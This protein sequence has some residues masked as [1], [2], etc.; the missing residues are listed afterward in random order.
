MILDRT[1]HNRPW[2][3][4]TSTAHSKYKIVAELDF[5]VFDQYPEKM[6]QYLASLRKDHY[7]PNERIVVYHYDTDFYFNDIGFTL[8]NF[9]MCLKFLDIS[10]SVILMFTSHQGL[11]QE[12]KK[13]YS[14]YYHDFD[15]QNDHMT[16]VDS[17]YTLVQSPRNPV[18]TDIDVELINKPFMCLFGGKRSHRVFFL[19]AL[20]EHRLLEQGICS[21]GNSGVHCVRQEE[22]QLLDL[23]QGITADPNIS[24]PK[25]LTTIPFSR[26]NDHWVP[27]Q[28]LIS[29][30][31]HHGHLYNTPFCH[32]MIKQAEEAGDRFNQTSIKHAFLYVSPE[33]V[34]DYPYPS[35]TEKMFRP[36]IYKRP[37]VLLGSPNTIKYLNSIGFKTFGNYWD[38]GYDSITDPSKRMIAV[39]K[40]IEQI[41]S[42]TIDQLKSLC[43]NM[44]Q[45]LEHNFKHYVENYSNTNLLKKIETI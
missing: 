1:I 27:N 7:E 25:F 42:M 30:Y 35:I 8:Y 11:E 23:L 32:P 9:L 13:F 24:Y 29:Y 40:I 5:L 28:E 20:A 26:V 21:W 34:F 16:V 31:Q 17:N 10:P 36:I 4:I 37:F 6:F 15:Y 44:N 3:E 33:S 43:Y 18:A 19:A 14:R 38:E 2:P 45:V 41:S 12:V 39:L 22:Y